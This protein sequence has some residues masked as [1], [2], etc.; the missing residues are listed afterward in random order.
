MQSLRLRLPTIVD[1]KVVGQNWKAAFRHINGKSVDFVLCEK[2]NVAPVF[3]IERD[4]E[5][6]RILRQAGLPLLRVE[7]NGG[8]NPATVASQ[9]HAAL[10]RT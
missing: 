3:A 9:V 6:E 8:F 10:G 5:M 7:N 2:D 4:G 1:F